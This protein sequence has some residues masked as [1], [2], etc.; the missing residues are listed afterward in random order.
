MLK[1][2]QEWNVTPFLNIKEKIDIEG[3]IRETKMPEDSFQIIIDKGTFDTILCSEYSR[4][5]ASSMLKEVY[6]ILKP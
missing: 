1:N 2:T 5:H 6:R 3:D 4:R